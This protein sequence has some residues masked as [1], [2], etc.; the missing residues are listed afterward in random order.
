MAKIPF[1]LGHHKSGTRYIGNI[2]EA[3]CRNVGMPYIPINNPKWFGFDLS[4]RI[5][6]V[7]TPFVNYMNADYKYIRAF[8]GFRAFHVIRDPRDLAISAYYSHRYSHSTQWWPELV[9]HRRRLETLSFEDG[10][11]DDLAFT[12]ALPTDGFPI[13][14]FPAMDRWNYDDP[15]IMEV[16][17]EQLI[18]KP[19]ETLTRA[20]AYVGLLDSDRIERLRVLK[21]A[22]E[23]NR[24]EKL[25]GG[26]TIGEEN[27]RHHYRGGRSGESRW[28]F[29]DVHKD[30]F[31]QNYPR[32]LVRTG[33]ESDQAW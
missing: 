23:D 17:F 18:A 3:F 6:V 30:W 14:V 24:F 31:R 16:K 13:T 33:Y 1:F 15:D 5:P 32:L 7:P 2:M 20:F 12:D 26:R 10:L 25:S 8:P 9:A 11:L 27:E 21:E 19:L 22:V 29:G 4:A 28:R